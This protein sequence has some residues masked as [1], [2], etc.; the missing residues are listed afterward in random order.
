VLKVPKT[1]RRAVLSPARIDLMNLH[2]PA[3]AQHCACFYN[4]DSFLA[5][6]VPYLAARALDEDA[7]SVIIAT[8][9]HIRAIDEKL[10]A[11][12]PDLESMR[13]AGRYVALI[14]DETLARIL[15]GGLPDKAKF[16][17]VIG[18]VI[19]RAAKSSTNGF[20]LAFGEMVALLCAERRPEAALRL[21]QLWNSLAAERH[22]SLCCAYPLRTF[23]DDPDPNSL[24]RICSE[25]SLVI[26]PE[27]R[28]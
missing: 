11:L 26:P 25:H 12:T 4:E 13:E 6:T 19:D 28:L 21:E 15:T 5:E 7:S 1:T 23:A 17:A 8:P 3:A 27:A 9:A 18:D 16:D 2:K 22:F 10:A 20:V 24:L 14:A